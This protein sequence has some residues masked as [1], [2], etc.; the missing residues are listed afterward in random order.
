LDNFKIGNNDIIKKISLEKKIAFNEAELLLKSNKNNFDKK[1][2]K[3]IFDYSNRISEKIKNSL[4]DLKIEE[5]LPSGIVLYGGGSK[6]EELKEGIKN[7]LSL[8]IANYT[9]NISDQNTD[10]YNNYAV[11][12]NNIKKEKKSG[13]F[14]L[15][16]FIKNIFK[17]FKI[18]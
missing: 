13:N 6:N 12:I 2:Q 5:L 11:I 8:P 17:K 10:Y 14:N 16:K 1:I 18:G 7:L 9:K 3:I 15:I 4:E